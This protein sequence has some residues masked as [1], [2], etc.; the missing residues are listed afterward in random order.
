M[1]TLRDR[2]EKEGPQ[3]SYT[4]TSD[5]LLSP[6]KQHKSIK[7][8]KQWEGLCVDCNYNFDLIESDTYSIH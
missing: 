2:T 7:H 4:Y 5:L 8:L 6:V 3:R 1:A